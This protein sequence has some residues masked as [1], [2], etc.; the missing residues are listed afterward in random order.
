MDAPDDDESVPNDDMANG[1]AASAETNTDTREDSKSVSHCEISG[2]AT[3]THGRQN[4]GG[5]RTTRF[6]IASAA[7]Y[8]R[9]PLS[10]VV[11]SNAP[12]DDD[13]EGHA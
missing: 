12:G 7:M 9:S 8:V 4:T 13:D 3:A 10:Q 6:G 11:V 1:M 5:A 2:R